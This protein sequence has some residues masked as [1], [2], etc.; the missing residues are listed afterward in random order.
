MRFGSPTVPTFACLR[1]GSF[2]ALAMNNRMEQNTAAEIGS[3]KY[4]DE[5][6]PRTNRFLTAHDITH[7]VHCYEAGETTQKFSF[8]YG[9]Q[10]SGRNH[11]ARARHRYPPTRPEHASEAAALHAT[12]RSLAWLG[13]RFRVFN[14]TV[15]RGTPPIRRPARQRPGLG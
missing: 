3:V 9:I 4:P 6:K 13:A 2:S 7:I 12:G 15:A 11:L 8:R 1:V 10:A 14:T 5:P